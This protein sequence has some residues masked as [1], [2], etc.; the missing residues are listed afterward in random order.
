MKTVDSDAASSEAA[1]ARKWFKR[2][3]RS[4]AT[5][6]RVE[7]GIN[8]SLGRAARDIIGP[9]GNMFSGG[10]ELFA[11]TN[12]AYMRS[13]DPRIPPSIHISQADATR[14]RDAIPLVERCIEDWYQ[15]S[16]D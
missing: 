12:V 13:F 1:L 16:D 3:R 11:E 9:T 10:W 2:Y 14:H 8:P 6:A 5:P 7:T 15:D 4:S